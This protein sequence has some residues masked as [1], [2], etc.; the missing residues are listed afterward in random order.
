[1]SLFISINFVY[2]ILYY[3]SYTKTKL[4]NIYE[5]KQTKFKKILQKIVILIKNINIIFLYFI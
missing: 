4:F 5:K 3:F 1:M 2:I